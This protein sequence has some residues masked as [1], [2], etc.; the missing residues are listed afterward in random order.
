MPDLQT[1]LSSA[2]AHHST[3]VASAGNI[4]ASQG[5]DA[6]SAQANCVGVLAI[7]SYGMNDCEQH[8][9]HRE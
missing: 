3:V 6:V 2:I 5:Y 1:A 9:S 8:D 4:P 7:S